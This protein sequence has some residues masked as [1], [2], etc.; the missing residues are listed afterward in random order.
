MANLV[1]DIGN[2]N[3]KIAVFEGDE[4]VFTERFQNPGNE[5]IEGILS[6]HNIKSAIISKVKNG[7]E[8]WKRY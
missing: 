4:I 8:G 6:A 1:V 5:V 2:T 3:T 7:N